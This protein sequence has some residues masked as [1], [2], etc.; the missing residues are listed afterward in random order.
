MF[1]VPCEAIFN[2]HP[3]V[4]RSALVE[5]D[6]T[7]IIVIEKH[8]NLQ[9]QSEELLKLGAQNPKTSSIQHV[10][11]HPKFPVDV[12]HNAKIKRLVLRDWAKGVWTEVSS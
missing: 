2:Q 9:C 12:R 10:L 8:P 7:P 1:P 3:A 6:G 11:F 5:I 4:S